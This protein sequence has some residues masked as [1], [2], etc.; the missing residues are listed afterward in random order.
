MEEILCGE[1]LLW[2]QK[3]RF[4][5]ND[6]C[7]IC[8]ERGERTLVMVLIMYLRKNGDVDEG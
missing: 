2:V 8:Q 1:L 3:S 6:G 5:E 4:D 7:K